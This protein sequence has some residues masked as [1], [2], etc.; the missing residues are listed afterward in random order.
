MEL[1]KQNQDFLAKA[2]EKSN[3][4]WM[5]YL[6]LKLRLPELLLMRVDKMSM[7][8]SLE[9]RVPFL[10]D[11]FITYAMGIPSKL[12][13]TNGVS[14]YILK[15]AVEGIIPDNIIHRK[16]QGF[17]VPV[18][19]WMKQDLGDVAQEKIKLFNDNTGFLNDKYIETIFK[20]NNGPQIW[21]LLNL[22]LWWEYY[23]YKKD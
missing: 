13:T 15:K 18:Y 8:V 2:P 16:K 22:A 11:R 23:I 3:L 10:D 14:K 19:D 12:K 17:G 6:D 5:T 21:Y 20:R 7:A 1:E 9:A 4:N